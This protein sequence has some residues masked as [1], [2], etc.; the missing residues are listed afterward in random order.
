[1]ELPARTIIDE[2]VKD[3]KETFL[4][5]LNRFLLKVAMSHDQIQ[6]CMWIMYVL[7]GRETV[8][9]VEAAVNI[10]DILCNMREYMRAIARR[11]LRQSGLDDIIMDFSLDVIM[12]EE[13]FDNNEE[14]EVPFYEDEIFE[15]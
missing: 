9:S 15:E 1:M 7:E 10:M 8:N 6:E 5:M 12:M 14:V 13:D 4:V 3:M 11:R 2:M